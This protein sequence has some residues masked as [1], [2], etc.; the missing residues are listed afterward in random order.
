MRRAATAIV[1]AVL[2]VAGLTACG[3]DDE[4]Q[5]KSTVQDFVSAVNDRDFDKVCDLFTET[6]RT[7]LERGGR[8]CPQALSSSVTQKRRNVKATV[9][10]VKVDGD[11]ASATATIDS[12]GKKLTDQKL[13]LEKE[14]GD[15]KIAFGPGGTGGGTSPTTPT[16]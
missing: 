15:W 11:K 12:D 5:V 6:T 1:V 4:E 8:K 10:E 16:Q 2:A 13:D 9:Q 3:N 7:Q 14:D